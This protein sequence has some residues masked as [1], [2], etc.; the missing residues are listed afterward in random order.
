M[1]YEKQT[2]K[3]IINNRFKQAGWDVNDRTQVIEEFAIQFSLAD[4]VSGSRSKYEV[5]QY[6][7]Y[8]LLGKDGKALAVVEAKKSTVDPSIGKE[9]AK[10]YCYNIQKEKGGELPF[11]FYTNGHDIYFWDLGAYPPKK[12]H[13]FPTR[14]DLE[15]YSYLRK[16]RKSLSQ[17]FIN[18]NIAGREYQ[19]RAIRSVM[20]SIEKRE[21]NFYWLWQLGQERP[22]L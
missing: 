7:D 4:K 9:Q 3:E 16:H 1:K 8:V 5:H 17:E 21:L 14:D 15:R 12:V 13:G 6:S 20:E 2:R 11:C 19:I 18:T 22:E 10:Q